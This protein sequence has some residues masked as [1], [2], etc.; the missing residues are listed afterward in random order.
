MVSWCDKLASTPT[1]GLKLEARNLPSSLLL[2]AMSPIL[3]RESK[4][5][6]AR[7]VLD[8]QDVFNLQFTVDDGYRYGVS[9]SHISV[10][11]SH[12]MQVKPESGGLPILRFLSDPKPYTEVLP[13]ARERLVDAVIRLPEI[14]KR[15]VVRVGVITSTVVEE[16]DMP[17]GLL[18]VL[19]YFKKP[20]RNVEGYTFRFVSEID[21]TEEFR[22]RCIHA[23]VRGDESDAI[24][25]VTLDWQRILKVPRVMRKSSLVDTLELA[26]DDALRYFEKLAIGENFHE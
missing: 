24:P 4:G 8:N 11:F 7:F 15:K 16:A 9:P 25:T 13:V 21:S 2:Q 18:S 26:S 20:W 1:V 3:D 23:F 5:D 10:A 6:E 17:P 19:N 14:E 12:R 22:D